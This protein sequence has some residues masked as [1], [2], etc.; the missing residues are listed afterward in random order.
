M[1]RLLIHKPYPS[2]FLLGV[3][4]NVNDYNTIKSNEILKFLL[5]FQDGLRLSQIFTTT[6]SDDG[7]GTE[8]YNV[9]GFICYTSQH[10]MIFMRQSV[11]GRMSKKKISFW[12]LYNDC[13]V[14]EYCMTWMQV[15]KYCVETKCIPTLIVFEQQAETGATITGFKSAGDSFFLAEE[16]VDKLE[17]L[18]NDL[19]DML[20]DDGV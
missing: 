11:M 20:E 19:D 5:T 6:T 17:R 16:E 8:S 10:Y 14:S 13:S 18:S 2:V 9:K 3:N 15:V 4:W 1:Q 7:D 12:K